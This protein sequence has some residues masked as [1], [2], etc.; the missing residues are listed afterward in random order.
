MRTSGVVAAIA[1]V[2]ASAVA[3]PKRARPARDAG[4][5]SPDAGLIRQELNVEKLDGGYAVEPADAGLAQT[6]LVPPELL[7]DSPAVYPESLR[8]AGKGGQ[9]KLEL[10]IDE[11]GE[12]E[13]ASVVEGS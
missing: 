9:V 11:N 4:V 3:A 2:A 13:N 5:E 8:P 12:V 6:Q 1:L 7:A 10:L